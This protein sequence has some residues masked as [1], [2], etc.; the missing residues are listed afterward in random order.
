[1]TKRSAVAHETYRQVI[2]TLQGVVQATVFTFAAAK[3]VDYV[4]KNFGSV[5]A[6]LWN[7]A[8]WTAAIS[9]HYFIL[10][11]L[12][13]VVLAEYVS[14]ATVISRVP[15][16]RDLA[17]IV[18]MGFL[19][20]WMAL[21]AEDTAQFWFLNFMF[22]F[23]VFAIYANT[24]SMPMLDPIDDT[25]ERKKLLSQHVWNQAFTSA[26][27]CG[28]SLLMYFVVTSFAV[29]KSVILIATIAY[30]AI[31]GAAMVQGTGR[32]VEVWF[33]SSESGGK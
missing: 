8:F 9:W 1:M 17:I 30:G 27:C 28:Y 19:Q 12:I 21:V 33:S 18:A 13:V 20:T 16:V 5:S 2:F 32:F 4:G 23:P 6:A 26:A 31:G 22:F 7:E 15:K 25:D 3:F 11:V 10:L 24:L 29:D 14:Y